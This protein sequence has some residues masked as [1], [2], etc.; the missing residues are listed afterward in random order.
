M[1]ATGLV[2][3][4]GATLQVAGAAWFDHQWGDFISVGSGWDWYAV[5]LADGTDLTLSVVR[6]PDGTTPLVYGTLVR[7]DGSVR[8]LDRNAFTVTSSGAWSS[9]TTGASYPAGWQITIAGEG[10]EIGLA[11]T[12]ADQELDTRASTGVVYWEGS[13]RVTATRDG[14]PLSGEAYVELTGYGPSGVSL[15]PP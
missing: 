8:H 15:T 13:Q 9:P 10:L 4:G 14:V 2:T 1:A 11:P 12:V 6:A 5:N 3:V 7:E